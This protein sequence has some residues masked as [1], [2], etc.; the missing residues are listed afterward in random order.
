LRK[1]DDEKKERDEVIFSLRREMRQMK[2][3]SAPAVQSV[4]KAEVVEVG[5][6]ASPD[7]VDASTEPWEEALV[8][9]SGE[10]KERKGME[11]K[12]QTEKGKERAK[13][14]GLEKQEDEV[15]LDTG[16]YSPYEDLSEYEKEME[17][18]AP[19]YPPSP[20][21]RP[22][23]VRWN[24]RQVDPN[25]LN[26]SAQRQPTQSMSTQEPLWCTEFPAKDPWQTQYRISR[27]QA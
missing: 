15:M 5:V 20:K 6:Q 19:V 9:A 17:G 13:D 4:E 22:P 8:E 12:K 14:S 7:M 21:S 25:L 3:A 16:R 26:T 10:K 27:R 24:D 1:L 11:E 23:D 2:E 18:V